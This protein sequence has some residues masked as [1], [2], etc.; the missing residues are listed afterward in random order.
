MS[1]LLISRLNKLEQIQEAQ[2]LPEIHI[3][4]ES[5]WAQCKQQVESLEKGESVLVKIHDKKIKIQEKDTIINIVKKQIQS[6]EISF[7]DDTVG[8][9]AE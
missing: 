6:D 3:F 9:M 1:Q 7:L 4:N 5:D 8:G 2:N